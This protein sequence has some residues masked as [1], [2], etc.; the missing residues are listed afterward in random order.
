LIFLAFADAE[1]ILLMLLHD[2]LL[3][4]LIDLLAD[5]VLIYMFEH[6]DYLRRFAR[7]LMMPPPPA[8]DEKNTVP[9]DADDASDAIDFARADADL[10]IC[11]C[12]DERRH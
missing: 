4:I 3:F 8:A 12:A 11:A 1:N 9:K 6:S 7:R 10:H 2:L 5:F